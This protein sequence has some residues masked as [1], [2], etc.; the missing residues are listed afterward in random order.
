M[1]EDDAS[2]NHEAAANSATCRKS[3]KRIWVKLTKS[4]KFQRIYWVAAIKDG[5]K[6]HV[7]RVQ[8]F[9]SS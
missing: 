2:K 8:K 1:D 6:T 5:A 9:D 7:S 4:W 3:K